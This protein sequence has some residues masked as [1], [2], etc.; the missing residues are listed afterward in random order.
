MRVAKKSRVV[1]GW[2]LNCLCFVVIKLKSV[3]LRPMNWESKGRVLQINRKSVCKSFLYQSNNL[4]AF[5]GSNQLSALEIRDQI[6]NFPII[7]IPLVLQFRSFSFSPHQ[8]SKSEGWS[9]LNTWLTNI[10]KSSF[11][12]FCWYLCFF[13][14]SMN[15]KTV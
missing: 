10:F 3:M 11:E 14:T 13:R 1:R 4:L 6:C 8:L 12:P 9:C 7:I 5:Q 15:W 2:E